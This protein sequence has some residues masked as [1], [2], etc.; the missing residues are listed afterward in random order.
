MIFKNIKTGKIDQYPS[1]DIETVK[2]LKRAR[3]H[4]LKF[5]LTTGIVHRYDGF[6]EAVSSYQ[7]K[8]LYGK[9]LILQCQKK[10]K[11]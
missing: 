10:K 8:L 1:G 2:W 7:N 6:K 9:N 5:I 4:C 3:G 11:N